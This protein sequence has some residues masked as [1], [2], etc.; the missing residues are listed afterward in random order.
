M[1]HRKTPELSEE[2]CLFTIAAH[3]DCLIMQYK[4]RLE[5]TG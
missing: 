1:S 2:A 5:T 3:A 4:Q